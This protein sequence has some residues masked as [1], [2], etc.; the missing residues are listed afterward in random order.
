MHVVA[1]YEAL[2]TPDELLKWIKEGVFWWKESTSKSLRDSPHSR[3][4]TRIRY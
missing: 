3:E 2:R 1:Q 4:W